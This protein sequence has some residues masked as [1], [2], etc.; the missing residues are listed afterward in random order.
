MNISDIIQI[1]IQLLIYAA[2]KTKEFKVE[3]P[4][5]EI[6]KIPVEIPEVVK[7]I[8]IWAEK[9]PYI[10]NRD[11]STDTSGLVYEE[12]FTDEPVTVLQFL[13]YVSGG[14]IALWKNDKR[15][16]PREENIVIQDTW[17]SLNPPGKIAKYNIGD[18]LG[19]YVNA[20]SPPTTYKF[21]IIGVRG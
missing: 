14:E 6:P 18:K 2:I 8:S 20:S 19:V 15:I 5:I 16:Y 1:A 17:I 7:T 10:R 4:E 3:L 12:V 11:N 13:C 21:I 9:E